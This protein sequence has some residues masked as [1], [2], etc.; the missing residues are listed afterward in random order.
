MVEAKDTLHA[1]S[2]K[3][4]L[5]MAYQ[6]NDYRYYMGYISTEAAVWAATGIFVV[7]AIITP[8][9]DIVTQTMFAVP[10][11]LLYLLSVLIAKI[12]GPKDTD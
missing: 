5:E 3:S 2:S 6:E 7:A 8:T 9:P 1:S 4:S 10:M 11:I 12:F